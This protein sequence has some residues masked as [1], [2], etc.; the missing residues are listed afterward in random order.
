MT[1][2]QKTRSPGKGLA[3]LAVRALF[4]AVVMG[5]LSAGMLWGAVEYGPAFYGETGFVEIAEA[6]FALSTALIFLFSARLDKAQEPC[7][8]ILAGFLF[9]LF[10]RESDYFFDALIS[11]HAWKVGVTLVLVFMGFYVWRHRTDVYH[12]MFQFMSHPSFGVFASG[13][14]VL[15]VFSRLF[16]YGDFWEGLLLD[17]T[18]LAVKQIVAEHTEEIAYIQLWDEKCLT[19]TRIVEESSEQIGYFLMLI[20]SCEYLHVTRIRRWIESAGEQRLKE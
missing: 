13:L 1:T 8:I 3:A 2:H 17:E 5:A 19:I 4:Y 16:G 10:I 14:L 6:T 7:A 9:C 11:R 18:C 20:S 15:I 12:S